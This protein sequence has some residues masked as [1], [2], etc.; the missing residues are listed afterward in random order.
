MSYC[1]VIIHLCN[2]FVCLNRHQEEQEKLT[3]QGEADLKHL[4]EQ[5]DQDLETQKAL[6]EQHVSKLQCL[7]KECQELKLQ[8]QKALNLL[9]SDHKAALDIM[10]T[11]LSEKHS[12]ELD[13]LQVVLEETNQAQLEAQEAELTARH[14]QE[15]EE[16]ETRMLCNMDTLES[17]YLKE[18]QAVREEKKELLQNLQ[19]SLEQQHAEEINRVKEEETVRKKLKEEL[20][21]VHMDKFSAMATELHQAHQVRIEKNWLE[22]LLCFTLI[23][24]LQQI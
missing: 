2:F 12:A 13:K 6:L 9:S 10:E 8:H 18:I 15:M 24:L 7:E 23:S 20:T 19:G 22:K 4:R 14:K 11:E 5:H 17:T 1:P 3:K 16:L 21:Q